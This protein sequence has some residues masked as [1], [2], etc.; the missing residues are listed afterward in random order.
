MAAGPSSSPAPTEH[1][2]EWE[3]PAQ[4][5]LWV[6][7]PRPD[8]WLEDPDT[9]RASRVQPAEVVWP[10]RCEYIPPALEEYRRR[11][12]RNTLRGWNF[13]PDTVAP[14][15]SRPLRPPVGV[16]LVAPNAA[17]SSM[18]PIKSTYGCTISRTIRHS[19]MFRGM[20]PS[21]PWRASAGPAAVL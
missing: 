1:E 20:C 14:A 11:F 5:P 16:G 2:V 15:G 10:P 8:G 21:V 17:A 9:P 4:G 7:Y 6:V 19:R 3:S 18:N 12:L 13:S